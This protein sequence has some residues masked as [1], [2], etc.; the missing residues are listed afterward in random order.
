[1]VQPNPEQHAIVETIRSL[2]RLNQTKGDIARMIVSNKN[3][4]LNSTKAV[5][6]YIALARKRNREAIGRTADESLADSISYWSDKQ[7]EALQTIQRCN[8]D[9]EYHRERIKNCESIIDDPTA[10]PE[11]VDIALEQQKRSV[12]L[13]DD[14]RRTK[15][16]AERTSMECQDRIDRLLGNFAPVKVANTDSK[17]KDVPAQSTQPATVKAATERVAGLLEQLKARNGG[18][19]N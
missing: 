18:E 7:R 16:T 8:N 13:M 9:I 19:A 14:A 10:L 4:G 1:M 12:Q 17:G 2:L 6:K 5:G 11:R 3:F 15:F